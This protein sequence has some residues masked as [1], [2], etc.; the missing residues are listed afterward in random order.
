MNYLLSIYYFRNKSI[1][2]AKSYGR[3]TMGSI[4]MPPYDKGIV[5][6]TFIQKLMVLMILLLQQGCCYKGILILSQ[7]HCISHPAST[8]AR[9]RLIHM[10]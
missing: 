1:V 8:D 4:G 6:W 9:Y 5:L 7:C 10:Q 2:I 3:I